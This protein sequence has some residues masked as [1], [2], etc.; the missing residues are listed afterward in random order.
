MNAL[1]VGEK[2][3]RLSHLKMK[4]KTCLWEIGSEDGIYIDE[5]FLRQLR[6]N[7]VEYAGILQ[8]A[9]ACQWQVRCKSTDIQQQSK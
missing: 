8:E 5:P 1:L 6:V 2:F 9:V 7:P 4:Q 3:I